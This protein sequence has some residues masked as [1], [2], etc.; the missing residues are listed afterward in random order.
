MKKEDFK[1]RYQQDKD[2]TAAAA[3]SWFE[4]LMV[5]IIRWRTLRWMAHIAKFNRT[6]FLVDVPEMI[7]FPFMLS[8]DSEDRIK[9]VL[10]EWFEKNDYEVKPSRY[11][12]EF[13]V[14]W[15]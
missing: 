13:I 1:Q 11:R 7:P 3:A 14:S 12:W 2:Y 4:L 15:K 5:E 10:I 6:D 9:E 8:D